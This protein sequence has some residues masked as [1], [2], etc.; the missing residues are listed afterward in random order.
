LAKGE[1]FELF[2]P[3]SVRG[4]DFRERPSNAR[5]QNNTPGLNYRRA[6]P[7]MTK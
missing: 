7:A 4:E 3:F 1:S 5:H 6:R 2:K